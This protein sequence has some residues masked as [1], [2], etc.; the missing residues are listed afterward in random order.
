MTGRRLLLLLSAAALVSICACAASNSGYSP[1]PYPSANVGF[2]DGLSQYGNW[3][4]VAPYGECWVPLDVPA[5]WR[6]YTEGYWVDTDYGWLWVSQDPWGGV[7]YHYGRWAEDDSYGWVWVPDD[8]EVWAPAWVAWRY[9]G[10]YVGW[11]PLPPDVGWQS[12]IGIS[13]NVGEVDRRTARDSWCFAPVREFGTTR[14][15]TSVLPPSRNVTLISRTTN[16]TRYDVVNSRAAERGL[17]LVLDHDAGRKFP[18][19]QVMESTSPA[20]MRGDAVRGRAIVVYRPPAAGVGSK[21]VRPSP[22]QHVAPSRAMIQRLDAEQ[23][24]FDQRMQRERATL[25]REQQRELKEQGQ[26]HAPADQLRQRHQ[27]E[28]QA[29]QARE[30]RERRALDQRRRIIQEMQG[31]RGEGKNRDQSKDQGQGKDQGHGRGQDKSQDNGQG[32]GQG[33]NSNQGKDRDR[34]RDQGNGGN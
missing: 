32:K 13:V 27:E 15:R 24:Q 14:I 7:P 20:D 25:G 34:G 3:E 11:A 10:G 9:G 4:E 16:V 2:Y 17:S 1:S 5:G 18:R 28:L 26:A 21:P 31:N 23:R 22:Q 12:G 19:Y 29:Q 30:T 8:D 33:D 6:P